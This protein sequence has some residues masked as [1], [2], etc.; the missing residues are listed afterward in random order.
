QRRFDMNVGSDGRTPRRDA[1][2]ALMPGSRSRRVVRSTDARTTNAASRVGCR[3]RRSHVKLRSAGVPPPRAIGSRRCRRCRVCPF[4]GET[5]IVRRVSSFDAA[6]GT[7]HMKIVK[8]H[9]LSLVVG[10]LV[11]GGQASAGPADEAAYEKTW[12]FARLMADQWRDEIKEAFE[13]PHL[14]HEAYLKAMQNA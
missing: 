11:A 8:L 14:K 5:P 3:R 4:A 6:R 7:Q 2:A 9:I 10:A 1:V 13:K 12:Q